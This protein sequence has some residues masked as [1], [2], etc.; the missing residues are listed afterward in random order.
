MGRLSV[1]VAGKVTRMEL[2]TIELSLWSDAEHAAHA[3]D[4]RRLAV[5]LKRERPDLM[6]YV[7]GADTGVVE[8]HPYEAT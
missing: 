1:R 7:L 5:R 4:G 6:V 8:V 2:E 3:T